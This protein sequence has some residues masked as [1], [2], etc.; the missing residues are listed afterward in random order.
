MT[1]SATPSAP[2][3]AALGAWVRAGLAHFAATHVTE[4]G[5][6]C[7]QLSPA[8]VAGDANAWQAHGEAIAALLLDAPGPLAAATR[9]LH[10]DAAELFLLALAGA[11]EDHH[12]VGLALGELQ[13]GGGGTRPQVHTALALVGT[14]FAADL[15]ATALLGCAPVANHLL[16]LRGDGPL[17]LRELAVDPRLWLALRGGAAGWPD[18][19]VIAAA[20]AELV[21]AATLK[22]LPHLAGL[23]RGGGAGC[24]VLRGTPRSGRGGAAARL[25]GLLDRSALRIP[26]ERWRGAP[27]LGA[28]CRW[29]GWLPVLELSLSAGESAGAVDNPGYRGPLALLVGRDGQVDRRDAV[30]LSVGMPAPAERARWWRQHL[31]DA[32]LAD[33]A[34][35]AG[36]AGPAIAAVA[37]QAQV[38]AARAGEPLGRDHL[39]SARRLVGADALRLLAQPVDRRVGPDALVCTPAVR[40]ELERFVLRCRARE[41]LWDGLGAS[42]ACTATRGLRALFVGDSGTGKTLAASWL[43]TELGAPLYRVDL[44][45]VMNKY[46][47]ESEKNLARLLDHAAA[48]DV[49]ILFD[50][51]DALFGARGDGGEAG[52]RYANM[53]TNFLLQR[54]EEHPGIAI[55]TS[56][57]R[58]RIDKAFT[59]R[60]DAVIEF[61]LP[62]PGERLELWRSH[63]GGRAGDDGMCMFLA[64]WCDLPGGVIRNVVVA[65]AALSDGPIGLLPL[66]EALAREYRKLGRTMPTGLAHTLTNAPAAAS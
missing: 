65:A 25:A 19:T 62:G 38:L 8:T 17:P 43:A 1:A 26:P 27:A 57:S 63:L 20:D 34:A 30:E 54:I 40:G 33:E 37:G 53:L 14:L 36:L 12:L 66:L 2:I 15:D 3:H 47:G 59:R 23:L 61:P 42:A 22:A 41:T 46:V 31:G 48:H 16:E 4:P 58:L 9:T 44:S 39:R 50:E 49:V 32:V 7:Q 29:C 6:A 21:D 35:L 24:A 64:S 11:V 13:A 28:A 55:L 18:C 52:E 5:P 60:L 51:A 10:L 45:A 56:N